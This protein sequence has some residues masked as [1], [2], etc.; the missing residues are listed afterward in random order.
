MGQFCYRIKEFDSY[1][2]LFNYAAMHQP[3]YYLLL[4]MTIEVTR[5]QE[6]FFFLISVKMA[7]IIAT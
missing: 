3:S 1:V 6:E 7:A 2:Y 5:N 4:F